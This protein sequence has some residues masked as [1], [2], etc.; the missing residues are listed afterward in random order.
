[1]DS[2][3]SRLTSLFPFFVLLSALLGY[4]NPETLTWFSKRDQVITTAL[5]GIMV[6]MGMT[7]TTE[8]FK[9]VAL[10]PKTVLF[11]VLCQFLFM[12]LSALTSSRIFSLPPPLFLGLTLVGCSPGGTASNLV[13][14]IARAD[15]A[16]SVLM[17]AASTVLASFLTPTLTKLIC[18]SVISVDSGAL[19]ASTAKV[20]LL[21]VAGGMYLNQRFPGLS[22]SAGRFTPFSSVVLVSLICGSVVAQNAAVI[23]SC[24]FTLVKSVLL[25]HSLGFL[26]GYLSPLLS[27]YPPSAC[28]TMSIET[29][30]QNSALAVVLANGMGVPE[31]AIPGAVSATCH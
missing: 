17:T 12:P 5:G 7:L 20:V 4:T 10:N 15:V 6:G 16:L 29:G 22:K 3:L 11:G 30:M 23:S 27:G 18:G 9:R 1:L 28:R 25:L 2:T 26:L 13:A 21:P 14:L 31:A 8:D 24:G 19:F